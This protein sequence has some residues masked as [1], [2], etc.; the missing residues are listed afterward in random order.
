MLSLSEGW[1]GWLFVKTYTDHYKVTDS[2]ATDQYT[3]FISLLTSLVSFSMDRFAHGNVCLEAKINRY[4]I[5]CI[6]FNLYFW[7]SLIYRQS[8]YL[9]VCGGIVS[10]LFNL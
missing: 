9:L 8:L 3:T 10:R 1:V 4:F 7:K 2:V 5:L 6:A